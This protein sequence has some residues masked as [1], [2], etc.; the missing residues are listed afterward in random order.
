MISAISK[1]SNQ[2][3]YAANTAMFHFPPKPPDITSIG[4]PDAGDP[5]N[6]LSQDNH[7]VEPMNAE[8]PLLKGKRRV[9]V[10]GSEPPT[11]L[12]IRAP[13][14]SVAHLYEHPDLKGGRKY[15]SSDGGPFLIHVSR[16]ESDPASGTTLNPIKFGQ[17]MVN[18]RV[19]N[20]A[21]DG[22]KK[23]GRNR[24]CVEF[25]SAEAA[26]SFLGDPLLAANKFEASIPTFNVTRMGL[27]RGVPTDLGLEDF[28]K[29]VELPPGCGKILKARRLNRKVRK[30]DGVEW[31]PTGTVVITFSGQLLPA[32]IYCCYTSLVV[33]RYL[34]PTIQ[35]HS[36][37]KFGHVSDQCRSK[38]KCYKCAKEHM[39]ISCNIHE[40][41]A[42]CLFCSGRHF[43]TSRTCPE[44]TRQ[45]TIKDTMSEENISYFEACERFPAVKR[46]YADAAQSPPPQSQFVA[47]EPQPQP[48]LSSPHSQVQSH[49]YRKTISIPRSPRRP[50]P[51]GYDRAA[52]NAII[53]DRDPPPPRNGAALQSPD[54][55]QSAAHQSHSSDNLLDVLLSLLIN[56]FS[57][58]DDFPLPPNVASKLSQFLQ[59]LNVPSR[60]VE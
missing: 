52:H 43:A 44:H 23:V 35:C 18:S 40:D 49:S 2:I 15:S 30:T 34:L 48:T 11:K 54:S 6:D 3:L 17:V 7:P 27:V 26:N 41:D 8:V 21:R 38:P 57:K 42:F 45:R 28:I 12:G 33:E 19:Q 10:R 56:M 1:C 36:C 14:D 5:P 24:V 31:I 25:N 51:Q 53:G 59:V 60:P 13:S 39:G 55:L 9:T 37:C 58:M 46:T 20:V 47:Y 50:L 29:D 4:D 22:I 16:T 32:K